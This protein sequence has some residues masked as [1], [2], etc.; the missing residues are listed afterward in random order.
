MREFMAIAKALADP[1]RVR[2]LL[3]LEGRELC[4]CQLIALLE[5]APSTVS[6]H[7]SILHQ[8]RLVEVRKAGKWSHYRQADVNA[9]VLVREALG[10]VRRSLISDEQIAW[11]AQRMKELVAMEAEDI[12]KLLG[13][14]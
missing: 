2:L 3:A 9:P 10:W 1:S 13:K 7:L 5:L 14:C 8:A 12:C 6:K 11:D 4:V